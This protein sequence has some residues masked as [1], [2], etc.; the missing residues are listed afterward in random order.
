MTEFHFIKISLQDKNFLY[1]EY[2]LHNIMSSEIKFLYYNKNYNITDIIILT[3][4]NHIRS[5]TSIDTI[6]H[7]S[8]D[9][10]N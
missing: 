10:Y 9:Y 5:F 4:Y 1:I 2:K 3:P 8:Y 7:I 6:K